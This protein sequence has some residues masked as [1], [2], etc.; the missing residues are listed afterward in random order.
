MALG[1]IAIMTLVGG[2]I[3]D[4]MSLQNQKQQLQGVVDR[5]AIAAAQELVVFKGTDSRVN[6]VANAFVNAN[7]TEKPHTTGA[8][9]IHNGKDVDVMKPAEMKTF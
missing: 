1:V 7:Y 9:V 5:A 4:Y 2:G 6:S 3:V 8:K